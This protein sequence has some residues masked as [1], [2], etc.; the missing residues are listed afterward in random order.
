MEEKRKRRRKRKEGKSYYTHP[1]NRVHPPTHPP[2]HLSLSTQTDL[3]GEIRFA[4]TAAK[5]LGQLGALMQGKK[6]VLSPPTHPTLYIRTRPTHPTTQTKPNQST[7]KQTIKPTHPPTH[8]PTCLPTGD[9]MA[10]LGSEE[11]QC[12]DL[13]TKH[14][15]AALTVFLRYVFFL[16]PT[17]PPT[18]PPITNSSSFKP[19]RSPSN[20]PTHPPTSLQVRHGRPGRGREVPPSP[21]T[22]PPPKGR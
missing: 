12:Y 6:E 8:P 18:H 14:G 7:N 20:P 9:R 10:V 19:P 21:H 4:A 13:D 17:H 1:T 5:R 11:M 2:T 15:H 22:R 3:P 16:P